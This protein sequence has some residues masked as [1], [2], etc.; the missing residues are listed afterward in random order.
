MKSA[1]TI[2]GCLVGY[3]VFLLALS[4]LGAASGYVVF[5]LLMLVWVAWRVTQH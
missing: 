3:G 5:G 1:L 2:T 4:A